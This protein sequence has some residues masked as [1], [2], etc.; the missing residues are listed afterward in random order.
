MSACRQ[1]IPVKTP[2]EL[3][4]MRDACRI[5]AD[6]TQA[7]LRLA[8]P[9]V[10]TGALDACAARVISAAGAT[11]TF[12]GYRGFPGCICVSI[13]EEL[14]HGIPGPRVIRT[15]DIVSV[16]IGVTYRGMIGD[17]ARTVCIGAVP[18]DVAAL[19]AGAR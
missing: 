18:G 3:A 16:D 8:R 15:G 4:R 1:K 12:K 2:D 19:V 5:V 9:G 13:N 6:T 10:T 7:V 14:I 17:M 11:P